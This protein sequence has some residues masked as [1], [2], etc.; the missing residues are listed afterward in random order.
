MT[1]SKLEKFYFKNYKLLM[2]I[3]IIMLV[4]ALGYLGIH[5]A[6]TGEFMNKDVSLKG[7]ITATVYTEQAVDLDA[8]KASL[9]V[10]SNIRNLGDFVT[11]K[12]MGF[13]V[14]VSDL[15]SE[16]L[17]GILEKFLDIKLTQD[18]FSI[19]ET[20]SKLGAAFF[21]QLM[22]ALAFAFILMAISVFIAFRT[23]IPSIA[24]IFSAFCEIVIAFAIV[25]LSGM[26]IST[27]GIVAFLLIIGYSVD[28]DILLTTRM[29]RKKE[30]SLFKRITSSI[31]TGATMTF[32]TIFALI[33]GIIFITSYIIREMFIIIVIALFMDLLTTYLTNAGILTWYIIRKENKR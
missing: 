29:L 25:T 27:A 33:A 23:F 8:L 32:T 5:Y 26:Q 30:W 13:I 17:K 7:G 24:V 14:E 11:G 31:K 3:P 20:G 4:I 28:T 12:Q 1:E 9:G 16:Q 6:V 10:P 19:E 22:M 18:N 21:R 15:S 2:L